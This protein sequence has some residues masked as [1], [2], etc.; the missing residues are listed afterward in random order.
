M[1]ILSAAVVSLVFPMSAF[2]LTPVADLTGE[3]SGFG[4][5]VV[6]DLDKVPR[7]KF[8]YKINADI[9][10]NDN[11]LTIQFN[12][13]L[14]KKENLA[15]EYYRDYC[16]L[17]SSDFHIHSIVNGI[18]DGS[19]IT[20]LNPDGY[21]QL[22]GWYASAGI[23][24]EG[25]YYEGGDLEDFIQLSPT[26]F[27]VVPY[28]PE[29]EPEPEP[30]SENGASTEDERCEEGY[31]YVEEH[32]VCAQVFPLGEPN[33]KPISDLDYSE[34][35]EEG[36]RLRYDEQNYDKAILYFQRAIEQEPDN[37]RGYFHMAESLYYSGDKEA[38]VEYYNK[39]LELVP[40][41]STAKEKLEKMNV[42]LESAKERVPGWIKNNAKWWSEGLIDD[43]DFTSGIQFMI[44]E[45]IIDIPDLPETAK[46]Q[47]PDLP[48][49]AKEQVPD[50][51]RNNA[52][53]WADGL[54]S[55]KDFLNGIKYLI[56]K[57]IIRV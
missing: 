26:N 9:K 36:K 16:D 27:E 7:C 49:T 24:L 4:Q 19:R 57:R 2:A 30:S 39:I 25:Q 11:E 40:G 8:H 20:V 28:E 34:L 50:W 3:W 21:G 44:K 48:E 23:K 47:V 17:A 13:V 42:P 52:K 53:W 56:E 14:I 37:V 22:T 54:I 18:L 41:H 10:Q 6:H 43:S 35:M 15:P 32:G 38:S 45:K 12:A 31:V 46:E 51:V 1:V 29:P 5:T 33:L 55:E